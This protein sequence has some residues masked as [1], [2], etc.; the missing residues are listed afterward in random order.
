[1]GVAWHED[2]E[3]NGVAVNGY[4]VVRKVGKGSFGTVYKVVQVGTEAVYAMKVRCNDCSESLSCVSDC[5]PDISCQPK[6][7]ALALPYFV[8]RAVEAPPPLLPLTLM[9]TC[10]N[11]F[12]LPP[13]LAR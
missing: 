10:F 2:G 13:L 8:Y 1:M 4:R 11:C 12:F 3:L 5:T 6:L 7:L 9:D